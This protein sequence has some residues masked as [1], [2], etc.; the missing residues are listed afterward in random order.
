MSEERPEIDRSCDCSLPQDWTQETRNVTIAAPDG[1]Q[2]KEIAFYRNGIGMELVLIPAGEFTMGSGQ[3][4]AQVVRLGEGRADAY[5]DEHPRHRAHVAGP[6]LMGACQVTQAEYENLMGE[7][8]AKFQ[9]PKNPVEHVCWHDAMA[10][11]KRLSKNEGLAYRLPTEA[12]WEYACRAGTTTPFHT[13]ETISTDHANYDGDYVYANGKKGIDRKGTTPTA[14]FPANAFGLYDMHGNVW[15]WC[16]SLYREYPYRSDDGREDL[17]A[18]GDRVL[19]GGSWYTRP[20][21]IRSSNRNDGDP[22]EMHR[23]SGFRVCVSCP[24]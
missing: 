12:E 1:E 14:S 3:S 5:V 15:E 16:Q 17:E 6:F 10:F 2:S 19:R 24:K 22:S 23:I 18:E 20:T 13:G 7:N 9:D 11:C 21:Y 4:A 8:P